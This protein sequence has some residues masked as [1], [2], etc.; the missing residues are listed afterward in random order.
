MATGPP[1]GI[2]HHLRRAMRLRDE[3]ARTD[4]QLLE[5]YT[6]RQDESALAALVQRHGPMVWGVCRRVLSNHYDAEDAFQATFLVLVRKAAAIAAPEL[7]AN[8]L[9]GVAH[10]TA[11]KARAT[12]A[13]RTVRERLVTDMPEPAVVEKDL[14]NDLRPVLDQELS[15]LPDI[16]RV[17]LVLCDLEGK[18]RTE[19]ARQ[20][21]LPEGTVGSRLARARGRLAKRLTARGVTLSGGALAAMLAPNVASAG[22]PDAVVSSTLRAA[23]FL[24]L[25]HVAAAGVISPKVAALTDGVLKAMLVSKLKA[26]VAVGLVLGVLVT[27]ATVLTRRTAVAQNGQSPAPEDPMATPQKPEPEKESFTAWGPEVGG[28]Q[29]GLGFRPGQ[30]RV[31]HH[32]ESVAVVVRVRNVGKEVV[33]FQYIWAFLVENLPK[34]TDAEGKLVPLPGFAAL[35]LHHPRSSTIAPGK[36][37]VLYE[38]SFDL[39]PNGEP[40]P[41]GWLT[42]HGTGKLSLQCE[43]VVG[44]TSAN[45]VHPNPAMSKL[46]T[47]KLE[48]DV[49][50]PEKQPQ[51]EEKEGFTA[52]GQEVGGRGLHMGQEVDGL[53]A[54][55]GF[56]PGEKRAYSHGETVKL[57]VR[58]R[59]VG[60][61]EVTFKYIP[62]YFF[63]RPP[64]VTDGEGKAAPQLRLPSD[65]HEGEY[66]PKEL[67]LAPGKEVEL[68][69]VKLELR[70]ASES[71]YNKVNTLYG[72]GKFLIHY[73]RLMYSSGRLD[74]GSILRDLATGKLDLEVKPETP[75]AP[76]KN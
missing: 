41:K 49:K 7:L 33:E 36:E 48:L 62:A 27:G 3:A 68:A 16:Y 69:E 17:V 60:Q 35:G 75:A 5:D 15:R 63:D 1:S 22:V 21:G 24:A 29:A 74:I 70:P 25:G 58:V 71:G 12:V 65:G 64:S 39:R 67:T 53:Q 42:I 6:R 14:W 61:K 23:R 20:L 32:G 19:A 44:P 59:N 56:R 10:Q 37:V 45:P 43:R 66:N 47:G 38:W 18:T 9:Y 28:L 52:W 55:L 51:Q 40:G 46:A 57:V 54:G 50:E 11:R 2:L 4:R 73:E 26:V 72:T 30:K 34:I 8:W 13:R 31:Y 76:G